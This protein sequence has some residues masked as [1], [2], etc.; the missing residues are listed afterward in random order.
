MS[1]ELIKEHI[2]SITEFLAT[3][4]ALV[5][6]PKP[7]KVGNN[8]WFKIEQEIKDHYGPVHPLYGK[9][10]HSAKFVRDFAG[11]G[12]LRLKCIQR[13]KFCD[14]GH[15]TTHWFCVHEETREIFDPTSGQFCYPGF[16]YGVDEHMNDL[17]MNARNA[18]MGFSYFPKYHKKTGTKY[19]QVVPTPTVLALGELY[20]SK[21]G[22]N[23]HIDWWIEE[24]EQ[25][26]KLFEELS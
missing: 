26:R 2:D 16:T 23:G 25:Q 18:D 1:Y 20:K 5:C 19:D 10:F 15:K 13:F 3:P 7:K 17:W 4:E 12:V 11:P 6:F 24:K 8:D 14:L 9:C 21:Y 22:T